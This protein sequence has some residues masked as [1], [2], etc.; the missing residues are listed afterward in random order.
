MSDANIISKRSA[1][2]SNFIGSLLTV[3]SEH[4]QDSTWMSFQHNFRKINTSTINSTSSILMKFRE[5]TIRLAFQFHSSIDCTLKTEKKTQ[6]Q[7]FVVLWHADEFRGK[8]ADIRY[9]CQCKSLWQS[10]AFER[11]KLSILR[12][13]IVERREHISQIKWNPRWFNVAVLFMPHRS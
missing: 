7:I 4:G 11:I 9:A 3:N 12:H 1:I 5:A 13:L 2:C 10:L 8:K 6:F